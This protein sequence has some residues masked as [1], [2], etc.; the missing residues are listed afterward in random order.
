MF[1]AF[2]FPF[3]DLDMEDL[4]LN[5]AE[6]IEKVEKFDGQ[7]V[8]AL[9]K[10]IQILVVS[11]LKRG[12]IQKNNEYAEVFLKFIESTTFFIKIE[13]IL[14]QYSNSLDI[15]NCSF[16]LIAYL[17]DYGITHLVK[18][19]RRGN[20][21]EVLEGLVIENEEVARK[22]DIL[23]DYIFGNSEGELSL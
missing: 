23:V 16:D 19:L 21:L 6:E 8:L 7:L 3:I 14:T 11:L 4:Y 20:M 12:T 9:L 10:Y 18:A 2:Y 15:L 22:R 5:I 1:V 13:F 17:Q